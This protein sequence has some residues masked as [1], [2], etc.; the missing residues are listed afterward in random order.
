QIPTRLLLSLSILVK[1]HRISYKA[2]L[3]L[4]RRT[5]DKG[6]MKKVAAAGSKT[7]HSSSRNFFSFLGG[8]ALRKFQPITRIKPP[9]QRLGSNAYLDLGGS[10]M[11]DIPL[12]SM[13]FQ[14]VV[15]TP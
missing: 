5:E 7:A 9:V 15:A 3:Q 8:A 10:D 12:N 4:P 13:P 6:R 2:P 14:S 1:V 11:S